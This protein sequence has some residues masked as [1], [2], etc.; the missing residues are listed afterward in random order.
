M[1]A[2]VEDMLMISFPSDE[3]VWPHRESGGISFGQD[4]VQHAKSSQR[5]DGVRS[6]QKVSAG[7][8]EV[9]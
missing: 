9:E 7:L 8:T 2:H 5:R 1:R 3:G 4:V 6:L